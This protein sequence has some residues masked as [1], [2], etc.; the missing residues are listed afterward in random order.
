MRRDSRREIAQSAVEEQEQL[1][2]TL[3]ATFEVDYISLADS[4]TL[5][6]VDM[7]VRREEQS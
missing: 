7:W 1:Q 6:E 2:P 5:E 3:K 4:D